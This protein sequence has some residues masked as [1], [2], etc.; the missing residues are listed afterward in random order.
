MHCCAKYFAVA[1]LV[2]SWPSITAADTRSALTSAGLY[3]DF[4]TCFRCNLT[5]P[6]DN[7]QLTLTVQGLSVAASGSA[8]SV[9]VSSFSDL[10]TT[11]RW[12]EVYI[13]GVRV[14][15]SI[16]G[17]TGVP[18]NGEF[19]RSNGTNSC[20]CCVPNNN[21]TFTVPAEWFNQRISNGQVNVG[22]QIPAGMDVDCMAIGCNNCA[23][24][25]YQGQQI[26]TITW[27]PAATCDDGNPC[28]TESC[29]SGVCQHNNNTNTCND[30]N[31]CTT[32]DRCANGVCS[33]TPVVCNDNEPCTDDAC[34]PGTGCVY[35]NDNT[36]SCS[37]GNV[38]NGVETCSNGHC[39]RTLTDCNANGIADDEVCE[40]G[41]QLIAV[42]GTDPVGSGYLNEDPGDT[43]WRN[44][45]NIVRLTFACPITT[46]TQEQLLLE[47]MLTEGTFGGDL[48]VN[49]NFAFT[50]EPGNVLRIWDNG[51]HLAH[52]S[53]YAFRNTGGLDG[54][55]ELRGSVC[56]PGGRRE[57]GRQGF[58]QR[59]RVH[60]C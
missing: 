22:Y 52:K 44:A 30:G 48:T 12:L 39:V 36:N 31:A 53:W 60:Q 14:T 5:D 56:G 2:L 29:V 54:R 32:G 9:T 7:S 58:I 40:P 21:H 4:L 42:I 49:D 23:A 11:A 10:R 8:V 37:D 34:N 19:W 57:Q 33:G 17:S 1:A 13:G 28:T 18:P 3:S 20:A 46:P 35:T 47:E 25:P 41:A 51:S 16:A 50:I 27:C 38:C 45:H 59:P 55:G 24:F 15:P 26:A 6:A 43:L